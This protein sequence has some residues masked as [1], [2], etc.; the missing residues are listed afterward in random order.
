[1]PTVEVV[2]IFEKIE[3]RH[4]CLDLS[5]EPPAVQQLA[6]ERRKEALAEG[7]GETI[8]HRTHR[9]RTAACR[10]RMPKAIDVYYVR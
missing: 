8:T 2:P 9:G 6:L 5:V 1:V 7:V 10:Q 4:P 3:H